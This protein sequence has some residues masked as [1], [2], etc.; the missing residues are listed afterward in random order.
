MSDLPFFQ[1]YVGDYDRKTAHLTAVEDGMY[2]RLLRLCWVSPGCKIPADEAW[3]MRKTRARTEEEQAAVRA[4]I[5]EFF[6]RAKGK[7]WNER[8]L[9]EFVNANETHGKRS[10]AGKRGA[11]A[12]ARK[13][14]ETA[15]SPAVA[16]PEPGL[17]KRKA[18]LKHT[19]EG[20]IS[21]SGG[22]GGDARE[23]PISSPS[24]P[25]VPEAPPPL[26]PTFREQILAACG[27]DPISGLTG[28]GGQQI[29]RSAEMAELKTVMADA[30]VTEAEAL[31]VISET[32]VSK[33]AGRDPG[34][35]GSLNF[36]H[37]PIRRFA[38]ARDAPPPAFPP[39]ST[40]PQRGYHHDKPD[41]TERLQRIIAAAAEGTSRPDWPAG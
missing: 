10:G 16:G 33:Q 21:D 17:S 12:K 23:P 31:Q 25:A 29:G 1:L 3:I 28:R 22:G 14:K 41:K 18:S 7:L 36:F 9:L 15:S 20:H 32:M 8:L 35:P 34:P 24:L 27:V 19:S 40:I 5:D 30:A 2:F 11:E 13:S 26:G 37:G 4:V 38:A 6:R 39:D